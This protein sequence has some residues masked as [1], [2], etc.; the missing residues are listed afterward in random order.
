MESPDDALELVNRQYEESS[1]FVGGMGES[2]PGV[3]FSTLPATSSNEEA[4]DFAELIQQTVET[5]KLE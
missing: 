1:H 5:V 4:M 2:D 3:W